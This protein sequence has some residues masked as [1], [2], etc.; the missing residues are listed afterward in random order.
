MTGHRGFSASSAIDVVR[1]KIAAHKEQAEAAA[2]M[3]AKAEK[4]ANGSSDRHY[5]LGMAF[6]Q[7]QDYA[8]AIE[9]LTSSYTT[10][11]SAD[12]AARIAL[13]AW[14]G[15]DLQSAEHWAQAAVAQNPTGK[16]DPLTVEARPSYQAVLAQILLSAGKMDAARAGAESA[17]K[18][19]A[20]DVAA[21]TTLAV[22]QVAAGEVAEGI[23][24]LNRAAKQASAR[25]GGLMSA[26]SSSLEAMAHANVR[27]APSV[28]DIGAILRCVS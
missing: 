6:Y 2:K 7:L 15:G 14:R 4:S 28:V 17:V 24:T 1:T 23:A 8:S 25:C 26:M 22:T 21:T 11:R 9:H 18:L 27:L 3:L 19:D 20:N 10:A 16:L 5:A 13:A 12:T